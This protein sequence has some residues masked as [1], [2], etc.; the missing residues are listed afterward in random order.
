MGENPGNPV[1]RVV[2]PEDIVVTRSTSRSLENHLVGSILNQIDTGIT[3]TVDFVPVDYLN[4]CADLVFGKSSESDPIRVTDEVVINQ[5]E[6]SLSFSRK[7]EKINMPA[8]N[9]GGTVRVDSDKVNP[10]GSNPDQLSQMLALLMRQNEEMAK[11]MEEMK[12]VRSEIVSLNHR[13]ADVECSGRDDIPKN[14]STPDRNNA[15]NA[16]RQE[17]VNLVKKSSAKPCNSNPNS[18]NREGNSCAASDSRFYSQSELN[19]RKPIDLDRWHIKF[20]GT[21]RNMTV[22]SFVFRI[23]KMRELYDVPFD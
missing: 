14:T 19:R 1:K 22:E 18:S 13:I 17:D 6:S 5:L 9:E 4:R 21:N 23:E 20:D 10:T 7:L 11:C 16:P 15:S 2:L 3:Q 12:Q 8:E